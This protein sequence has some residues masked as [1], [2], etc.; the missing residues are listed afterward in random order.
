MLIDASEADRALER[1]I[2]HNRH[3]SACICCAIGGNEANRGM[4]LEGILI[5]GERG[6]L[7]LSARKD[8]FTSIIMEVLQI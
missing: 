6:T 2:L 3:V 7:F 1:E 4:Y 8:D 5:I